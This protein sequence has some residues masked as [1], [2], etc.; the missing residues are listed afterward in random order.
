MLEVINGFLMIYFIVLCVFNVFVP[1]LVKPI[2]AC[3]SRPSNEERTIW[4]EVVKLKAEQKTISMKEEF[5]AYSKIQRKINKLEGQLK[6]DSQS[7][8]SKSIA[9][10]GSIQI[11]LQVV[12]ALVTIVSVI[13][14]RR[15]PIVALKTNLFPFTT[16]L[17][18]PSDMPNSIS[19]HVWVLV[20]NISLRTLLKPIIS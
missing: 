14:F 5:A 1:Y 19:T 8:M 9:I 3:F 15:E 18:Y 10:K 13:W 12:L 4:A 7:R 2:A 16:M 6:E 17:R 11:I 20:S